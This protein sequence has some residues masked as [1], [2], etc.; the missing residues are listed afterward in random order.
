MQPLPVSKDLNLIGKM[1]NLVKYKHKISTGT[2][3]REAHGPE[4]REQKTRQIDFLL[5]KERVG[6]LPGKGGACSESAEKVLMA[7]KGQ[8][9]CAKALG[10]KGV[11][12]S[13]SFKET[14]K[15][16][17]TKRKQPQRGA[18]STCPHGSDT[19]YPDM[20]SGRPCSQLCP[21]NLTLLSMAAG[22]LSSLDTC[23]RY[24]CFQR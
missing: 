5:G 20:V 4:L 13:R 11:W 12:N 10:H 19:L 6:S 24:K 7:L 2:G 17:P 1:G 9:L 22:W 18:L 21:P 16:L 8:V 14:L 15:L 23:L 3:I